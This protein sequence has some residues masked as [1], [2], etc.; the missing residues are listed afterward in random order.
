MDRSGPTCQHLLGAWCPRDSPR[1]QQLLGAT[2]LGVT[3]ALV[4][5][6]ELFVLVAPSSS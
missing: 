5:L 6:T 2:L 3:L 1:P 4:T